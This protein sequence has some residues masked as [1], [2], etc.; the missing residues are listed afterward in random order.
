MRA[1]NIDHKNS[2]K[3]D[4]LI[5]KVSEDVVRKLFTKFICKLPSNWTLK[6]S[7]ESIRYADIRKKL[8]KAG[9]KQEVID[10]YYG[11]KCENSSIKTDCHIIHISATEENGEETLYPIYM[12]EIKHQGTNDKRIAEGKEKQAQGNAGCERIHKNFHVAC[13]YCVG[14]DLFPY[15]VFLYGYDFSEEEITST[16]VSKI[17]PFFGTLN[18]LH[19]F[20]DKEF[21]KIAGRP[22][23]G[24]LFTSGQRFTYEFLF[25][26]CYDCCEIGINYYLEKY[27]KKQ[28]E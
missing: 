3:D 27:G 15:N 16:T 11:G 25:K 21:S 28:P 26:E 2:L 24:S 6:C 1:G 8:L 4:E 13:D 20:F 14:E 9:M 19:P 5:T 17:Q 10:R 7:R 22:V 23:G 12:G 18:E